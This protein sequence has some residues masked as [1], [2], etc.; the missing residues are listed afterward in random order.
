MKVWKGEQE[1]KEVGNGVMRK[2]LA[3]SGNCMVVLYML[4]KG[5]V[6]PMH[7]HEE[8]QFGLVIEGEVLFR[9]E[10]GEAKLGR[11]A[12]YHIPPWEKHS[13]EAVEDSLVIDIFV[14]S[15]KDF[16]PEIKEADITI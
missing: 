10:K 12:S 5:S 15:R 4:R 13:A 6:V 11:G 7:N 8:E 3:T 14:P 1:W 16:M 2:V 9:T